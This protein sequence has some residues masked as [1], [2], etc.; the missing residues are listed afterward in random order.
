MIAETTVRAVP[1]KIFFTL[2]EYMESF[3]KAITVTRKY[4]TVSLGQF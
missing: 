3:P 1:R 2:K 4:K